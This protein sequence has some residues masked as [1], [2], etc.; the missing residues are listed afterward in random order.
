MNVRSSVIWSLE[1]LENTSFEV[2][3]ALT[4]ALQ[5][6]VEGWVR[7]RAAKYLGW[8]G[9]ARPE[10]MG[11]LT[12]A[13][14][15]DT[16]IDVR[17]MAAW[18]LAQ[19]GHASLLGVTSTLLEGARGSNYP[20]IR[21]NCALQLGEVGKAD[22]PTRQALWHGLLDEYGYVREACM[23]A[24][25]RLAQRFPDALASIESKLVQALADPAFKQLDAPNPDEPGSERRA[26]DYAYD[27]L[28]L[29][30]TGREGDGEG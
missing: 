29:I 25:V 28:W 21:G 26:Y 8:L 12:A 19:L 14:Q 22:E 24:L 15:Q 9:K 1:H 13:L 7:S 18:S 16:E 4:A 5:Q 11:A 2:M 20:S 6:D 10:V 17:S 27:A 3:G 30:V 23:Q